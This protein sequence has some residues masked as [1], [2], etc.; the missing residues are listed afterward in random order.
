MSTTALAQAQ[1]QLQGL[2]NSPY[3]TWSGTS[4]TPTPYTPYAMGLSAQ[5]VETICMTVMKKFLAELMDKLSFD[6]IKIP[7]EELR[8]E[9][10]LE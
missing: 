6:G 8:K 3:T 1:A 9:L 10:G 5:D 4:T 2:Y 7:V